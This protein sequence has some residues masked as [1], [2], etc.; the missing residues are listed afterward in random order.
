[1]KI[2]LIILSFWLGSYVQQ[3]NVAKSSCEE[4]ARQVLKSLTPDNALRH[5][6]EQGQR[7]DCVRQSWMDKMQQLGIKQASFLIEYSWKKEKV[8][9]KI[10]NTRLLARL[11]FQL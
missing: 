10:K 1:M 9:F 4:R 7:G 8:S 3:S 2:A 11:L 6:L 5:A